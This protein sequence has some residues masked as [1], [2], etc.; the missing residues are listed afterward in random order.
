MKLLL[1]RTVAFGLLSF[2]FFG[3]QGQET[4]PPMQIPSSAS[5]KSGEFRKL[6]A[7]DSFAFQLRFGQA[8][9]CE[10]IGIIRYT[11]L[12]GR[13]VTHV[14]GDEYDG[15]IPLNDG[16]SIYTIKFPIT[17]QMNPGTWKLTKV[18]IGRNIFTSVPLLD[19]ATFEIPSLP[20]TLIH[21]ETPNEV[22]A[23]QP[24]VVKINVLEFPK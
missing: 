2:S 11:F 18:S 17:E 16:Q 1:F 6:A 19:D 24:M 13:R 20:R 14:P 4:A 22:T 7:G 5:I 10:G 8:P 15:Q 3:T 9:N 12:N 21:T 23:G